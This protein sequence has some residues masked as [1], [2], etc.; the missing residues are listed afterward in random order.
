LTP[1]F[2]TL[3]PS[4]PSPPFPYTTLFRSA[5]MDPLHHGSATPQRAP[6]TKFPT[7]FLTTKELPATKTRFI[8]APLFGGGKLFGG[9]E[10]GGE[11]DRKSTRLNSSHVAISYAVSRLKKK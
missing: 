9:E 8:Y 7:P 2:L 10:R 6:R 3:P 5:S 1:S 11:L 4:P